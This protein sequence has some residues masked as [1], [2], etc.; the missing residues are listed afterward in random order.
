VTG[1]GGYALSFTDAPTR[2]ATYL[3]LA[4]TRLRQPASIVADT[5][6]NLCKDADG[7]DYLI[8]TH[9]DFAEAVQPLAAHRQAQGHRVAMADV[10]DV[11]D[12]FSGGLL[13]PE[14]I[15]DFIAQ[16][17]PT[18]VLLVG[19][20]SYDFL[21]H[22]GY[23]SVNYIPPYLAM[24]D[25]GWSETAADNRYA[26]V[27]GDDPL[28]DVMLGRLPVT[29][30][31]EAATVVQKILS[32][33]QT[34]WLG[35][36]NARHVFVAAEYDHDLGDAGNFATAADAVHDAFVSD[37]WVGRKI[38]VDDLSA[39]TARQETLNS[40]QQGALLVS[41]L[42]HSSWHQWAASRLPPVQSLLDIHDVPNLHNNRQWP[43]VLSITC[44]TGF[45]HHPE[46][47]TLDEL[48]LRLDGGGAVA[49]WSPSG[50]GV[51]TGHEYLHQGFYQAVFEGGQTQLGPAVLAAKLALYS[52]TQAYNDLLETYHLFGD[53]AMALNLTIRPW[54]Y[55]I[56]LPIA[57]KNY[58]GG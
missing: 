29:T 37:P 27:N 2:P 54:P 40:W 31:A 48:L 8:V 51:A 52:Y 14:A 39:E 33:E 16:V 45:F 34:P 13:N 7:A 25:L 47:G 35:G 17:M 53:P 21:D 10:Q 43:V 11:Y 24:V 32:Y 41:F 58:S 12:E 23:G 36:W 38:Y 44:F 42:G 15:R 3:A 56:Y 5:P 26:A 19:D 28:P 46:Y 18:C 4:E 50:L 6:S 20:G 9:G 57:G 1:S 49:T 55:S 22:Y 30:V